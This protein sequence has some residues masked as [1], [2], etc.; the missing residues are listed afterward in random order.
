M[1]QMKKNVEV[2]LLKKVRKE[3]GFLKNGH[4]PRKLQLDPI[5][6]TTYETKANDV[7]LL[8]KDLLK[9]QEKLIATAH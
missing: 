7:I 3:V 6:G 2:L 8:S 5:D 4:N 1:L 9:K